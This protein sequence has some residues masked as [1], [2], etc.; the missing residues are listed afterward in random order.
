MPQPAPAPIKPVAVTDRFDQKLIAAIV[1][2]G[3]QPAPVWSIVH[4]I[5]ADEGPANRSNRRQ[6]CS[7]L[8]CRLRGLLR[9]GAIERV[10]K[11]RVRLREP[12][13]PP[14][15]TALPVPPPLKNLPPT[16]PATVTEWVTFRGGGQRKV[17]FRV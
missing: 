9:V 7:R 8:L 11:A 17:V 13:Q 12:V 14:P 16:P 4:Q 5:V 3:E 6:L 10:N 1:L 2:K 15:P